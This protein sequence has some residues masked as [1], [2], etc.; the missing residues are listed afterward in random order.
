MRVHAI[1]RVLRF[2]TK[3]EEKGFVF[4]WPGCFGG[5]ASE[6]LSRL[7]MKVVS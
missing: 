3:K 5:L 1:F 6:A 2:C 7:A 4:V